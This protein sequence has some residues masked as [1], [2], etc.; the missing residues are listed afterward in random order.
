VKSIGARQVLSAA[1]FRK[2]ELMRDSV[3]AH[4]IARQLMEM[5]GPIEQS[6][7]W[8]DEETGELC[9]CRPDKSIPALDCIVD[10]KT[11]ADASKHAFGRSIQEY[12]YYVQDPFYCDGYAKTVAPCQQFLFLTVSTTRDRARYPVHIYSLPE[13]QR[14]IGRGEYRQDLRVY[15][16]CR[17]TSQWDGVEEASLPDWFMRQFEGGII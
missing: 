9:R 12:R 17:A 1:E 6:H 11:T 3:M 14:E 16:E 8:H 4:P 5:D 13:I 15:A 7:F 10:V 2:L